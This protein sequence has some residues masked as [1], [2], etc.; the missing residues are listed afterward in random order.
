MRMTRLER[1]RQGTKSIRSGKNR[2]LNESTWKVGLGNR[3]TATWSIA[4]GELPT[5]ASGVWAKDEDTTTCML[6]H[7]LFSS[8]IRKHHCRHCGGIVCG[9]CSEHKI[10]LKPGGPPRRICNQCYETVLH[11]P[12]RKFASPA[13]LWIT[14]PEWVD[15]NVVNECFKCHRLPNAATR[16]LQHCRAC[17]NMYCGSCT[18]NIE[19]PH[20]FRKE[21]KQGPVPV[22]DLCRAA[23]EGGA[24]MVDEEPPPPPMQHDSLVALKGYVLVLWE[25]K[26]K[27][28]SQIK[29]DDEIVG[30]R[31][32][33][34]VLGDEFTDTSKTHTKID[35][36]DNPDFIFKV[37]AQPSTPL[38]QIHSS[39]LRNAVA[40]NSW[41]LNVSAFSYVCNGVPIPRAHYQVFEARHFVPALYV[42]SNKVHR[43]SFAD[44]KKE[45][46]IEYERKLSQKKEKKK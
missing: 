42:R 13:S 22:C 18:K 32:T 1:L 40:L 35:D 46:K 31:R 17:G 16:S 5:G 27:N 20:S 10:R 26:N 24:K 8:F 14:I 39:L 41:N 37:A 30:R 9:S 12:A 7:K 44:R 6:C 23:I 21:S 2:Q 25:N 38:P 34:A 19:V 28:V 11:A 43:Q 33:K 45:L 4:P 29:T 36:V 3:E 15:P